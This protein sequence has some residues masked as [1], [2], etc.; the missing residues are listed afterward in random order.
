[1]G[2]VLG[3]HDDT[4]RREQ[5]IYYLSKKLTDCESRYS[6]LEKTCLALVWATQRLRHYLLSYPVLL[7]ARMDPLKYLFEKPVVSGRIARWQML[8][9]E[10]DI[11]YVTQ[12]S[13]LG[14][15][16]ADHLGRHPLPCYEPPM[17]DFP[18][19]EVFYTDIEY[20]ESDPFW[21]MYFDGAL[22]S[23]GNGIGIVLMS[24]EGVVIP[25]AYQLGFPTTN[26]I[27]EYEAFIAGLR[28]ALRLDVRHLKVIGDSKL[29][30]SQVLGEWKTKDPRRGPL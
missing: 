5:A 16:I 23:K 10:F 21:T 6:P 28:A 25:K 20:G 12:K 7:L 29:V 3:Q 8:L 2:C 13:M 24:P 26:N 1:M 11:T 19:E 22:N 9:S 15:A 14:Q 30:I 27:T 17:M 4:G 18:D